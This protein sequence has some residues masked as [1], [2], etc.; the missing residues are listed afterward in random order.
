MS[1]K[2][3][4]DLIEAIDFGFLYNIFIVFIVIVK[5]VFITLAAT[6]WYLKVA[7]IPSNNQTGT[8]LKYWKDVAELIFIISMSLI[9]IYS[10][11]PRWS[12]PVIL[13]H[14]T[15]FLLFFYG[16]ITIITADWDVFTP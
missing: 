1:Y 5:V 11:Y 12:T 14:E 2:K 6:L 16:I 13:T 9:L 15:K 8:Q 7:H 4:R 3:S 10:F